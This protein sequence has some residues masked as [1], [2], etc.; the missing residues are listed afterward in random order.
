MQNIT[1]GTRV[2]FDSEYGPQKGTVA[3]IKAGIASIF[4]KGM[5]SNAHVTMP[6]TDLKKVPA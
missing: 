6:V 2:E 5:Q 3:D 4:V 1:T